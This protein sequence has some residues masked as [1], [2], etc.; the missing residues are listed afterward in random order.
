MFS[1]LASIESLETLTITDSLRSFDGYAKH[2]GSA[3]KSLHTL[4]LLNV[5]TGEDFFK[6]LVLP[7]VQNLELEF[8]PDRR[9]GVNFGS[10]V[11]YLAAMVQ[12]CPNASSVM[13][14]VKDRPLIRLSALYS[15]S[16]DESDGLAASG[17]LIS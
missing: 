15:D 2:R 1:T 12:A 10:A 4:R 6:G 8:S 3:F 17:G 9:E 13:F 5:T 16:E 14:H 7:S 11:S